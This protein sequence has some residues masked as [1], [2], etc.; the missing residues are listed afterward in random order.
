MKLI[1]DG[2]GKHS[3]FRTVWVITVLT[4]IG[5]WAV[6]SVQCGRLE[7][8]PLTGFEILA[9]FGASPLKTFAETN[10]FGKGTGDGTK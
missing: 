10:Q 8:L 3:S 5:T 4:I 9:L 7:P 1:Q 2:K 6:T